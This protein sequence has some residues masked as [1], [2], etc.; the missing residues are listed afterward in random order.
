MDGHKSTLSNNATSKYKGCIVVG[1]SLLQDIHLNFFCHL[2]TSHN[3]MDKSFVDMTYFLFLL[4]CCQVSWL[5]AVK[6]FPSSQSV[7]N[8]IL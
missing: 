5:L 8:L 6:H 7:E 1:Y 4:Q 3:A 2:L